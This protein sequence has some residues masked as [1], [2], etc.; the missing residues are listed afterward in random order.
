MS[1][2]SFLNGVDVGNIASINGVD[3]GSIAS[4]DGIELSRPV[5][6]ETVQT[7]YS[8]GG[9]SLFNATLNIGPFVPDRCT[10]VAVGSLRSDA[11]NNV[12]SSVKIGGIT[13]TLLHRRC[14]TYT[15]PRYM[16][17]LYGA[18]TG[19]GTALAGYNTAK[20][21]ITWSYTQTYRSLAIVNMKNANGINRYDYSSMDVADNDCGVSVDIPKEG[22]GIVVGLHGPVSWWDYYS[23]VSEIK[24]LCDHV[25][26]IGL[27]VGYKDKEKTSSFLGIHS[28]VGTRAGTIVVSLAKNA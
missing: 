3:I 21:Y 17:S 28:S 11:G 16:V 26:P 7:T 1:S 10:L 9:A 13:A 22:V 19:E 5:E 15:D 4:I 6:L 12:I 23:S 2:A 24:P 27:C 8:S 14:F 25:G 20:I 18:H